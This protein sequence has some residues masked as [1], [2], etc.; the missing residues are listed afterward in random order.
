MCFVLFYCVLG[1]VHA[2]STRACGFHA[3]VPHPER[4]TKTASAACLVLDLSSSHVPVSSCSVPR[5]RGRTT[6]QPEDVPY[7][8]FGPAT[9]HCRAGRVEVDDRRTEGSEPPTGGECLTVQCEALR[10]LVLPR[11]LWSPPP[12]RVAAVGEHHH[13]VV[14]HWISTTGRPHHQG[15]CSTM[16][17][18]RARAILNA[19]SWKLWCSHWL[20]TRSSLEQSAMIGTFPR[21]QG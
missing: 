4:E 2:A 3:V 5:R 18:G 19:S 8:G 6:H 7:G 15:S 12:H 1:R 11:P 21:Q 10:D 14:F 20:P 13:F 9:L 16:P 17:C